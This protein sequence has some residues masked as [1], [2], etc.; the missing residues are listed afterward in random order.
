VNALQEELTQLRAGKTEGQP[1]P[2]PTESGQPQEP[3]TVP[4]R[5]GLTLPKPITDAL[6]SDNPQDNVAAI[7]AVINDLGTLVHHNVVLQMRK[8]M[9][10]SIG[11]LLSEAQS[12]VSGTERQSAAEAAREDYYKAFPDHKNPLVLPII[13]S[14]AQKLAAEFPKLPWNADY[15]N[16]LG[17]RVQ[18]AIATIAGQPPQPVGEQT[19]QAPDGNAP[20]A[21][22]AAML[23]AGN[24]GASAVTPSGDISDDIMGVLNPF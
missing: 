7:Q 20:P 3:P 19:P 2:T 8:E 5:Y 10:T 6:I 24:R 21:R 13:Q 16:A 17:V 1:A 23:P 22:P 14:E 9:Q 11:G 15:I 18:N 4:A 12:V